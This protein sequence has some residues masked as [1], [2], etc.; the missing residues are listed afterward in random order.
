MKH[1]S[2]VIVSF[3][4]S[5]SSRLSVVFFAGR[6]EDES[7]AASARKSSRGSRTRTVLR[8]ALL[9]ASLLT[10]LLL[11][12]LVFLSSLSLSLDRVFL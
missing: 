7:D 12:N 2:S 3:L 6:G 1:L 9:L 5:A 10:D 8:R 11:K 4:F